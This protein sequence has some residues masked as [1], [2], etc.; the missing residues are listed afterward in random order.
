[1][2]NGPGAAFVVKSWSGRL[3][4]NAAGFVSTQLSVC[5]R[6]YIR[7]CVSDCV[8]VCVYVRG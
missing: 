4:L 3:L 8:S 1:M 6:V 2:T 7:E 5:E